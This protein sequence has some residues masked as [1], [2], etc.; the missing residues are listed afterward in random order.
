MIAA[1]YIMPI[2][3]GAVEDTEETWAY[4]RLLSPHVGEVIVVDGSPPEVFEA[5][6]AAL[7]GSSIRHVP[8]DPELVTPMG[9]V[10][11][12]LT[13]LRLAG[14]ECVVIADDDIRYTPDALARVVTLLEGYHVV[15]P[16]NYFDPLPWHARY[17]TARTLFNRLSGGDWPGTLGVRRS[18][19][20]D[21]GG[22]DGGAMFENL[23]LVRT[24]RAA[25]GKEAVPLDLFVAR[26]PPSARHFFSQRVRQAYDELARPLR[27]GLF[28]TLLPLTVILAQRG[29]GAAL[30][31]AVGA[32]VVFAE[33]GRRRGRGTTVFPATSSLLAPL[34][35]A[36]R[37]VCVW[38]A[39]GARLFL[40]GIPYRNSVLR[41]AA[42]SPKELRRRHR[43]VAF[44]RREAPLVLR[45]AC[46]NNT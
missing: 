19:L 13:G 30:V 39:L 18:V 4:L 38:L 20:R 43:A 5:H 7:R 24:V 27:F 6:A 9:K 35:L 10:G 1:S 46:G 32:F 14:H 34:W 2:R 41:L 45:R 44:A 36:E 31:V 16:Q 42:N 15:R 12:C 21:T 22:Y 37:A 8:V 23:E 33:A 29:R 40:G 26:R 28:L 17:D 25:E 3:H 11:G